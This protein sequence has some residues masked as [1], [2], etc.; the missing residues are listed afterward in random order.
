MNKKACSKCGRT[1]KKNSSIAGDSRNICDPC[2]GSGMV[3]DHSGT[4]T[5]CFPAGTQLRTPSGTLPIEQLDRGDKVIA[6]DRNGGLVL[7]KIK[8]KSHFAP[9]A[10]AVIKFEDGSFLRAT[11]HHA[12]KTCQ[13][14]VVIGKLEVGH[15]LAQPAGD[16]RVSTKKIVSIERAVTVEA[17][18][19]LII[20]RD[21][22]FI[23]EGIVSHSFTRL[24]SS[25]Y[26]IEQ[27]RFLFTFCLL[28][29][30]F[31]SSR[32]KRGSRNRFEGLVS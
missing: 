23:A 28:Q 13:S 8:K 31:L 26:A 29:L 14:W 7:R 15:C 21:C 4:S 27:L 17:V 20:E 22:T 2:G 30:S 32:A 25:R 9:A 18:F 6:V 16:S 3:T 19:N 10:I 24:R 11:D 1:G 12:V 5:T